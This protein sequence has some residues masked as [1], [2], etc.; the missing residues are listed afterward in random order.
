MKK[1]KLMVELGNS[2]YLLY[3]NM[4][5]RCC[6]IVHHGHQEATRRQIILPLITKTLHVAITVSVLKRGT[7]IDDDNDNNICCLCDTF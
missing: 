2:M 7:T 5:L 6:V 1:L 4:L 3:C